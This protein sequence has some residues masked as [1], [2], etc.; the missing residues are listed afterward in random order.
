VAGVANSPTRTDQVESLRP[1]SS[2][3]RHQHLSSHHHQNIHGRSTTPPRKDLGATTPESHQ[4]TTT[5]L[6]ES[7]RL[8]STPPLFRRPSPAPCLSAIL[9][10]SNCDIADFVSCLLYRP[11]AAQTAAPARE[12]LPT[13]HRRFLSLISQGAFTPTFSSGS[14][15]VKRRRTTGICYA[16][17][18]YL[19]LSFSFARTHTHIHLHTYIYTHTYTYISYHPTSIA[20]C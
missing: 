9:H 18:L 1:H 19:A 11:R 14:S 16:V 10:T 15:R 5:P 7:T 2:Y 20:A 6:T 8:P 3:C 12:L 4:N 17:G 13:S